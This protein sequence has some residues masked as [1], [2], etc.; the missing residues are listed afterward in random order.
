MNWIH[1]SI[2]AIF[3]VGVNSTFTDCGGNLT[4]PAGDFMSPNYPNSYLEN[5]DCSWLITAAENQVIDVRFKHL[6]IVVWYG[7]YVEG[8]TDTIAF[9]D[10]PNEQAPLLTDN[11]CGLHGNKDIKIRSSRNQ[12]FVVFKSQNSGSKSGFLANYWAHECLPFSYGLEFCNATCKC[13]QSNTDYCVSLT[14]EC[15]CNSNWTSSDCNQIADRC[16]NQLACGSDKVC[17]NYLG[18][19]S[20]VCRP[21]Y[22]LSEH[23]QCEDHCLDPNICS[24]PYGVCVTVLQG[25]E[26]NCKEGLIQGSDGECQDPGRC[27]NTTCS[28]FCG[29]TTES[30]YKEQ[31]YC[32]KGMKLDPMNDTQCIECSTWSYGEECRYQCPCHLDNTLTCDMANGT[33]TCRPGWTSATC[34]QDVDECV[35]QNLTCVP[36]R[37]NSVCY[38]TPGSFDCL[39]LPGYEVVNRTYCDDCG[40]TLTGPSGV[41]VSRSHAEVLQDSTFSECNWTIVAPVGQLVTLSFVR[42]D[43]TPTVYGCRDYGYLDVYDGRDTNSTLMFRAAR[44]YFYLW[45]WYNVPA[46]LRTKGNAMFLIRYPASC[47]GRYGFRSYGLD[48]YYWTH[49]CRSN[50]YDAT[51][52]TP[53]QCHPNNTATCDYFNGRCTCNLGWT[54]YDCSIDIDECAQDPFRCPNYSLCVNL[55][56][57]YECQCKDGLTLNSSQLCSFDVNSS[58]CT[59]KNCSHICV[60]FT[61]R[62]QNSSVELCYCPIGLELDADQCVACKNWKFGPDCLLSSETH[63]VDQNTLHHDSVADS[64][65][66]CYSNWT[67]RF[68]ETD[69]NECATGQFTCPPH[70][71]CVNTVGGY[72]CACDERNG[73]VQRSDNVTCEQIDCNYLFT[74]DSGVV[75]N[76]F[77]S[78]SF[79]NNNANCSWLITARKDYII[80]LRFTSFQI[81][82]NCQSNYLE[83][84]DGVSEFSPRFGQYC[85]TNIPDVVRSSGNQMLIKFISGDIYS[86]GSFYGVYQAHECL[87]FTYGK[88]TCDKNCS[89]VKEN[90]QFCDNINGECICKPGWTSGDCS[91]DMNEC[92]NSTLCPPNSDCIKTIGSYKCVCHQGYT[93]NITS[94][95]CQ[96]KIETT[97]VKM[98]DLK[99]S[100]DPCKISEQCLTQDNIAICKSLN[101][102]ADMLHT[103]VIS[104][105][106]FY[107]IICLHIMDL[108]APTWYYWTKFILKHL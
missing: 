19:F 28:H 103:H 23:G 76:Y 10:G 51:C 85:G 66:V 27:V 15:R 94:G 60:R 41:L 6:D 46:F 42:Y 30:P 106:L 17:V 55:P 13:N 89:C 12:L 33:C 62:D 92:P 101:S 73:F 83:V 9:Y 22:V 57:A 84:Y 93:F 80:T 63:C 78:K 88:E 21:G 82:W 86:D 18:G 105:L 99:Q 67:G 24:D 79:I 77:H 54:G 32:P 5:T 102:R 36:A 14:G 31:C 25:V 4:A 49:E 48:A 52:S 7:W 72:Q 70:A 20:C 34:T 53:C 47:S 45:P 65:C 107:G 37:D 11:L 58:A 75:M 39:C 81:H 98:C 59:W 56:G 61:P 38:N 64:F 71:V 68:C 29:V 69:V 35:S 90:T 97:T 91:V 96:G 87:D 1:P 16:L 95:Q 50:M 8:C 2:L 44:D 3:F 74:N 26:C 108:L 104:V 43:F 40:K 100:L